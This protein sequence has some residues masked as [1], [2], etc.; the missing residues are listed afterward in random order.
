MATNFLQATGASTAGYFSA[1]TTLISSELVALGTSSGTASTALSA[2]TFTSSGSFG[3]AIWGEVE[4]TLGT[5]SSAAFGT[6]A[7]VSGWF[8]RSIDGGTIFE[9]TSNSSNAGFPRPPDFVIPLTSFAYN[10][11]SVIYA[12]GLVK[13]PW[14]PCKVFI[15][16]NTGL[17]FPASTN[18]YALIKLGPVAVQY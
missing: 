16:N 17:T 14:S 11:S 10:S 3:Q 8:S 13:M 12:S 2:S 6:G 4:L 5:S 1:V 7:F 15:Q 9:S 18:G